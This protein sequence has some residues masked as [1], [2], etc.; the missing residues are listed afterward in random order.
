MKKIILAIFAVA[1]LITVNVQA[2]ETLEE[3]VDSVIEQSRIFLSE[4]DAIGTFVP[5][6]GDKLGDNWQRCLNALD[7][8]HSSNADGGGCY[9]AL[10]EIAAIKFLA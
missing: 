4:V 8:M 1:L 6:V 3:Q 7:T 10:N 9:D 5:A 2:Q